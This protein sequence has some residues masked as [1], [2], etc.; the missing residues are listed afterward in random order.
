M[1]NS[2]YDTYATELIKNIP[3]ENLTVLVKI[4]MDSAS[5]DMG[6]EYGESTLDR[7]GYI[8]RT[9]FAYMPLCFIASGFSQGAMGKYGPGRLVPRVIHGW[10][11]EVAL[12]YN[13]KTNQDNQ[14]ELNAEIYVRY[15]LRKYPIGKAIVQKI[16]WY[17]AGKLKGDL[18]DQISLKELA[19]AIGNNEAIEFNK[20]FK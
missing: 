5:V 18:W 20:F 1:N 12:E 10:L 6:S 15:D 9:E 7:V 19:M 4:F 16:D 3:F 14:A 11:N 2:T 13:R 8:I 17:E